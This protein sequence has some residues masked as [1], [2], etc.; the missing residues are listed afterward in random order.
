MV[1]ELSVFEPLS[2]FDREI[3]GEELE[4]FVPGRVFDTHI[5]LWDPRFAPHGK[6]TVPATRFQTLDAWSRQVFPRRELHYLLM[7]FPY[8]GMS[9]DGFHDFM[10]G[11]IAKS[12]DRLGSALVSP[13]MSPE[14][15][16]AIIERH[17]FSGLKPYFSF[18]PKGAS[19]RITDF[20]PEALVEVA[21]SRRMFVTLHLAKSEGIANPENLADLAHL[22]KRYPN[23][24]WI[25]A[26]CARAFNP[27][28]LENIIRKLRD[29]PN[30]FYDL[31]AVCNARSIWLLFRHEALSRIFF[32]TDNIAAGG[33]HGQYI[34]WGK[35]WQFFRPGPLP[36]CRQEATLVCYESL[37]SIRQAA[38][39][40]DLST[41]DIE[42]V[43]FNNA[44]RFFRDDG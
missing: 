29:M 33:I 23:V 32:G 43:F 1:D 21:D 11:E 12:P 2:D 15:L 16:D 40:A 10:A 14:E 36:H 37:R 20:F 4:D 25:L 22:T 31:A 39:M 38:D 3:W 44:D 19:S 24:R 9:F 7:G 13:Q 27:A 34:A 35:G 6:S 5:H 17:H 28:T 42:D 8:A 18:S 30:I 41:G 26:H